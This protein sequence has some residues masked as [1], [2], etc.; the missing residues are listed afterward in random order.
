MSLTMVSI[1]TSPAVLIKKM[2]TTKELNLLI[3][4]DSAADAIKF[5]PHRSLGSARCKRARFGLRDKKPTTLER[6][7]LKVKKT[8][9]CW[10][11]TGCIGKYGYGDFSF[12]GKNIGAHRMAYELFVGPAPVGLEVC[13]HCDIRSCV[14]PAHLFTGTGKENSE[15]AKLKG[16]TCVGV[17]HGMAVLNEE[18]VVAIR[19]GFRDWQRA[20]FLSRKYNV[21]PSAIWKITAGKCWLHIGGPITKGYS[22]HRKT[23]GERGRKAN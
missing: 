8:N 16:R 9:A 1:E 14:N 13:H 19:K 22:R 21:T 23:A 11:W 10:L 20:N 5:L 12:N 4:A 6:F 17:K 2:W 15:D 18:Q 7:L 3:S